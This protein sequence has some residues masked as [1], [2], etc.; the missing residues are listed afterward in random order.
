MRLIIQL[1]P[2][3]KRTLCSTCQGEIEKGELRTTVHKYMA[4]L[5]YFH[6]RCYVHKSLEP[7]TLEKILGKNVKKEEDVQR[8]REWVD[9]W[10]RQFTAKE[11]EVPAQ[12]LQKAV[13]TESTPLRRLLLEVFQY[14]STGDIEKLVAVTCKAWLHVSRDQEFW[15]T[16]VIS[17]FHPSETDSQGN[18]RRKYIALLRSF[19]WH[20]H[21]TPS[22][23]SIFFKCPY[24]NQPLCKPCSDLS[25]C[26]IFSFRK[27]SSLMMFSYD[28]LLELQIPN[29]L[30]NRAISSYRYM[31]LGKIIPYT[32][33]L[34]VRL[35][36]EIES[37]DIPA[38]KIYQAKMEISHFD[39]TKCYRGKTLQKWRTNIFLLK[40][41]GARRKPCRWT[42]EVDQLIE[43]LYMPHISVYM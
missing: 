10:N 13:V 38:D 8:V 42:Q 35:I 37:R 3:E 43:K 33:E 16:R 23:D 30:Y 31:I 15:R 32:E 25:D 40:F 26:Q 12:Y 18:Y 6:F 34:K 17:E 11:E 1:S 9:A 39:A 14:L 19:C 36:H 21:Y 22:L 41:I 7:L 20:C 27:F 4:G 5:E 24:F 2:T 29:F 28:L